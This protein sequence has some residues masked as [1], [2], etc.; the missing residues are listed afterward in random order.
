MNKTCM[1][2]KGKNFFITKL[3]YVCVKLGNVEVTV[4]LPTREEYFNVLENS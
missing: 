2:V 3:I 4:I 1:L